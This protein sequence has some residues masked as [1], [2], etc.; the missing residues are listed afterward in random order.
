LL[1]NFIQISCTVNF[2]KFYITLSNLLLVTRV[3]GTYVMNDVRVVIINKL[4]KRCQKRTEFK[5]KVSE[6]TKDLV[7]SGAKKILDEFSRKKLFCCFRSLTAAICGI[8]Q[9]RVYRCQI[10]DLTSRH[11]I[12][13]RRYKLLI[14]AFVLFS[15]LLKRFSFWRYHYRFNIIFIS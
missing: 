6:L 14:V 13:I 8:L 7:T 15:F 3:H 4:T 9:E 11:C 12:I 10:Q 2:F 5:L 1:P